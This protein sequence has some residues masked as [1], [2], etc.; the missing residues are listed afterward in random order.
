M[1]ASKFDRILGD[2]ARRRKSNAYGLL[3]YVYR[4]I[5][6]SFHYTVHFEDIFISLTHLPSDVE[7]IE[8]NTYF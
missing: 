5:C 3:Q 2:F 4:R 1:P 7:D 8:S 6:I